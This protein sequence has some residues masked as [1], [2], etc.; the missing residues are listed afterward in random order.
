MERATV[1]GIAAANA[2][3]RSL[4]LEEWP[5]RPVDRPEL[6][7]RGFE[8]LLRGIRRGARAYNRRKR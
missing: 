6:L 7:A 3:L 8:R 1:T 5:I 4:D 2:V